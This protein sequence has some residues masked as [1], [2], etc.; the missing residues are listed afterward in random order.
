MTAAVL[1][2]VRRRILAALPG[3][4][5]V[6]ADPHQRAPARLPAFAAALSMSG[7]DP[8]AM[9]SAASLDE[10]E[11]RLVLWPRPYRPADD[12]PADLAVV[13]YRV[14]TAIMAAPSDLGGLVW[15]ISPASHDGDAE[16]SEERQARLDLSFNIQIVGCG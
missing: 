3:I 14:R 2:E 7:S 6:S 9:G 11:L 8:V 10:Y 16:A 15:S 12:I 13:A 5:D 1:A 4:A